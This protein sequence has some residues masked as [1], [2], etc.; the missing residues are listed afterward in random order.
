MRELHNESLE[1]IV[2]GRHWIIIAIKSTWD[3]LTA[4]PYAEEDDGSGHS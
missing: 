1:R 4:N 3:A 2:G